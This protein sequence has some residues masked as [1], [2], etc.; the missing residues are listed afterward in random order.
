LE[1]EGKL[2]SIY[3]PHHLSGKFAGY[4]ECHIK[5]DWLLV[6]MQDDHEHYIL[7]TTTGSH[8]DIF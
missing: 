6:W 5:P 8:S 3:K 7:L 1:A 4:F 2:P